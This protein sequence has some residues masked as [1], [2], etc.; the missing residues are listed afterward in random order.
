MIQIPSML[1]IGSA[2]RNAGKTLFACSVIERLSSQSPIVAIKVTAVDA[3][4]SGCPRGGDG[5]G[6][7]SSLDG[8][9]DITEETDPTLEKDTARMLAAGAKRVYWLRVLK[10]HLAEGIRALMQLTGSDVPLVCE[11]NTLRLAAEPGLFLMLKNRNC[12]K[13]KASAQKVAPLADR[14]ITFGGREFDISPD[15]IR[16]ISGKWAV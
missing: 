11:S 10:S 7:C 16:L 3:A 13:F 15:D 12:E 5:C 4:H 14:V 8:P 6:V 9:Y 2:D 1:M